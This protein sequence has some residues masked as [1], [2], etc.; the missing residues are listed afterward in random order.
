MKSSIK[1]MGSMCGAAALLGCTVNQ[2]VSDTTI[3][4]TM[5]V[6]HS[7][8]SADGYY[9]LG[10]YHHGGSRLDDARKA[11][12]EALRLDAAHV[13]TANALAVLY[14]ESGKFQQAS[15]ILQKLIENN[16]GSDHLFSNL[17]YVHILNGDYGAAVTFL[18]KAVSLD[19]NNAR[20]WRSLGSAMEK[21]GNAERAQ[22]AFSNARVAALG[23]MERP[24]ESPI[25]VTPSGRG[26]PAL[27]QHVLTD[28]A[29]GAE[30]MVV[31]TAEGEGTV[32]TEVTKIGPAVYEVR[33]VE[34]RETIS[35]V[36]RERA[37]RQRDSGSITGKPA[38][39]STV[40]Y[41]ADGRTSPTR[42]EIS[43]GNGINGMARL[44]GKAIDGEAF[45]VV[46]LTNQKHFRVQSTRIEYR[47]GYEH[48]ARILANDLGPMVEISAGRTGPADVRLVLGRDVAG[49]EAMRNPD[50]NHWRTASY[51]DS[52]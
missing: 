51:V 6:R 33:Q 45:K 39:T 22:R 7:F 44:L 16:P 48:A 1:L 15:E 19:P 12:E 47:H 17:G 37:D 40:T 3:V 20:A 49:S 2:K 10:R 31:P 35:L 21:L 29:P 13:P 24:K 50:R 28:K 14:A 11:Y 26:K 34:K 18:E 41:A 32:R 4:P 38:H 5:N 8:E 52:R 23:K 27:L 46:R 30:D 25:P 36:T 42:I 9:A 43:N